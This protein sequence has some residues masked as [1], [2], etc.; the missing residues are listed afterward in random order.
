MSERITR[1]VNKPYGIDAWARFRYGEDRK[2]VLEPC[3]PI[4]DESL[5][6]GRL[7]NSVLK[8]CRLM[9]ADYD[10]EPIKVTKLAT[11]EIVQLDYPGKSAFVLLEPAACD[12]MFIHTTVNDLTEGKKKADRRDHVHVATVT[13]I[14]ESGWVA[15]YAP[16]QM[17]RLFDHVRLV[18]KR[19]IETGEEPTMDD[20]ENLKSV[21]TLVPDLHG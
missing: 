19:T 9:I 17:N 10:R 20:A 7:D 8:A 14:E 3:K 18:S 15:F 11:E 12:K 4:Q 5:C 2:N 16:L 21:F 1:F 13:Q 6:I